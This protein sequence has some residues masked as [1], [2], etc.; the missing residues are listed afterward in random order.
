MHSDEE[1]QPLIRSGS[2]T[3]RLESN[4]NDD[5][6]V[7]K[8]NTFYDPTMNRDLKHP[9]SSN[10]TLVHL[11]KGSM[12]PGILSMPHAFKNAGLYVGLFG[13][14]I[15]G[16]FCTFCIQRLAVCSHELCRRVNVSSMDYADVCYNAFKAG[17]ARLRKYATAAKLVEFIW[18]LD[19]GSYI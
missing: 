2:Q 6:D 16:L 12:G 14:M 17:P 5:T 11:L 9:T 13:S 10:E 8:P 15:L 3:V 19:M 4:K 18:T 7:T 1:Q